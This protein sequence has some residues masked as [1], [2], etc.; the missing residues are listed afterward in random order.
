MYSIEFRKIALKLE[1]RDGIRKTCEFLKIH[2]TS[3]WRW[4]KEI[5]IVKRKPYVIELFQKHKDAILEILKSDPCTTLCKIKYKLKALSYHTIS[6]YIKQLGFSRKRSQR[7]GTCNGNSLEQLI[8]FFTDK[9]NEIGKE[10]IVCI[11]ECG[12]SEALRPQYG[13]S[14]KNEPLIMKSSGGWSHYSLLL[15]IFPFGRIDYFVVPGAI[16][17]SMFEQFIN[18][19]NLDSNTVAL[20]DN[21]SIHKKLSLKHETRILYTPPYSP[22]FNAIELCFSQIKKVFRSKFVFS[23]KCIESAIIE[24]IEEGL[25][26]EKIANCYNHVDNVVK[27]YKK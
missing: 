11:D 15:A 27:K 16:N 25:N 18:D 22:E 26:P 23:N 5:K 3:L 10:N 13:Y 24:S 7:R 19:L 21:A 2:R 9:Y 12:F 20:M 8:A 1:K 4:R 14:K 17:K 6:K